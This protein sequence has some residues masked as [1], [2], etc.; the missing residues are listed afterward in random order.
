MKK[1]NIILVLA[2][3]LAGSVV[4]FQL[5][6]VYNPF[7]GKL[8]YIITEIDPYWS[9]NYTAYNDSWSSTYNATYDTWAY[10]QTTP[11]INTI[12]GFS[13]YNLT[14]FDINNY[15]LKSNPFS[16]Y[17]VTS[18]PDN[19]LLNTGDTALGD[20]NF[21]N[22]T[23]F[24]DASTSRVG[25]G[26]TSP[27][28]TLTV[29]TPNFQAAQFTR[30][31]ASDIGVGFGLANSFGTSISFGLLAGVAGPGFLVSDGTEYFFR[32]TADNFMV[33]DNTKLGWSDGYGS[34]G[35]WSIDTYFYR[36]SVGVIRTP[37]D[38]LIDGNVGIGTTSPGAPLHIQT[39][40]TADTTGHFMYENTNTGSGSATNAQMLGKSK[41]GMGQFMIWEDKGMR[42]GM[43]TT[44]NGGTGDISFT[45]GTDSVK[46]FI[47]GTTGNVGIGTT[48]PGYL[49]EVNGTFQAVD[50]YSGDGTQGMTGT[51][52]SDK[53]LVI[54]DGLVISCA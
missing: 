16:F 8:D 42:I 6:T 40:V 39:S 44:A 1:I 21:D 50:Y 34:G 5:Q 52:T 29:E 24:I 54:K 49:L 37:G 10:N 48:S 14:S 32:T 51:C 4:A 43:R 31:K 30:V 41:Y 33:R 7:T 3:L 11:A 19:Y 12:L 23:L 35:D 20:Y 46:M 47:N 27:G 22:N 25:I 17:N 45:A 2:I 26:T 18:F 13:Y 38:L 15:Y 28:Y 9:A 53:D 36:N